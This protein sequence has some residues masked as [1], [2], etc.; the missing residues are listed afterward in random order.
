ML[1]PE[2]AHRQSWLRAAK[3]C[4]EGDDL[5]EGEINEGGQ[6]KNANAVIPN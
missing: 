2:L 3:E 1:F 6:L 5:E 4:G